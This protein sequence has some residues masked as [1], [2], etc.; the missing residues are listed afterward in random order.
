MV[1]SI[2]SPSAMAIARMPFL[3][4]RERIRLLGILS[5]EP[6]SSLDLCDVERIVGRRLYDA[7]WDPAS[8]SVSGEQDALFLCKFGGSALCYYDSGYPA[9]LRETA[10]PPFMLYLRGSLPD[11][12]RPS[13]AIV[14]TRY[15]T[16][17]GLDASL[18]LAMEAAASGVVVVSGLARGIDSAAHRGALA[19]GGISC[20]VLGRGIDAIYPSSNKEL[21]SRMVETGG[22]IVSEYPP[23]VAPSRWTFPERNRILAGLCRSTIVVEAPG[24]SGALISAAFALE[25]G[26]DVYV[27][28]SCMGGPRSAGSDALVADG[29]MTLESFSDI[30]EDW[31]SYHCRLG[32]EPP[33]GRRCRSR[34]HLRQRART[35]S[36]GS[37]AEQ[38][39]RRN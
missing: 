5:T 21:A 24:G 1:N 38:G 35:R 36:S 14:G 17:R 16:G 2:A 4:A 22:G 9:I 25:E 8:W 29:A 10:R 18:A 7:P 11:S 26:R 23:G 19:A 6:L 32:H 31:R 3:S 34:R 28:A 27:A 30:I 20:A 37:N 13:L 12:T 33:Y 15:P 39:S